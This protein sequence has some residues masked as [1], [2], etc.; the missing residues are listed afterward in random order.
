MSYI[1]VDIGATNTRVANGDESGIDVNTVRRTTRKN[2]VMGISS[3]VIEMIKHLGVEPTSIGIGSIGPIDIGMGEI[4]N[5]PNFPY[6]NIP[7]VKPLKDEF[8]VEVS[9][10][11]DCAAAVL[12]EHVFGG[13][14]GIDNLFYVTFSTGLGGGAIVD[15]HLVKGKDGNAPEIGHIIINPDSELICGCGGRGHWE[16]YSSGMNIPHYAEHLAARYGRENELS[17]ICDNRGNLTAE[18]I[19]ES[20]KHGCN[21]ASLILNE[22]GRVNTI[23]IAD[24]VNIFDPEMIS[25]GGAITLSNPHLLLDPII[26]NLDQHII[27]R[28]PEII[29]TPLG[30][31]VVLYGALALAMRK[32]P[33]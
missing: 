6:N 19:F 32:F 23:G 4:R 1:A 33:L 7:V 31:E 18:S 21:L 24:I 30:D 14:Q 13:G 20:A 25:L 16:A 3:Q 8:D 29:I 17:R 11:N 27:N 15:G 28:K 10:L 5:T 12:G 26:E 2:G 9:I 22:L